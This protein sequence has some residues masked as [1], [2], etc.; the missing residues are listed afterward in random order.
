MTEEAK[1]RKVQQGHQPKKDSLTRVYLVTEA[2]D[3]SN[4]KIPQNMGDAAV[5]PVSSAN[6]APTPAKFEKK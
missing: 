2:V 5:T 6:S 3:L 1:T 4:L